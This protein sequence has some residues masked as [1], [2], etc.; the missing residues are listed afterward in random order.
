MLE[1]LNIVTVMSAIVIALVGIYCVGTYTESKRQE[2]KQSA[3]MYR[4]I[5]IASFL[6]EA[7]GIYDEPTFLN[8]PQCKE[9][10]SLTLHLRRAL[11]NGDKL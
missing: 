10:R 7:L 4:A 6:E 3:V 11:N 5:L 8:Y 1:F 2:K 9:L